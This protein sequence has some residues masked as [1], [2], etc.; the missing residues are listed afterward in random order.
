MSHDHRNFI[1]RPPRHN[2]ALATGIR[3]EVRRYDAVD[4]PV[5]EA[6][7]VDFSRQ[8]IRLRLAAEFE[9]GEL[10]LIRIVATEPD[11]LFQHRA[12]IHWRSTDESSSDFLYGCG[13]EA[14]V[15]WEVLGELLLRGVLSME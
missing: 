8:G 13:F 4:E 2:A 6:E 15:E 10:L 9:A 12:T 3:I 1:P 5:Y 7:L 11:F 14:Q